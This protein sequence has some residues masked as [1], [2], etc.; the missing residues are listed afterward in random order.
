FFPRAITELLV[1]LLLRCAEQFTAAAGN[2]V[3]VIVSAGERIDHCHLCIA[4]SGY[5]PALAERRCTHAYRA[6]D[7]RV[8]HAIA[9]CIAGVRA[10]AARARA[11]AAPRQW[12]SQRAAAV[13]DDGR[14]FIRTVVGGIFT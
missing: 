12:H 7:S 10:G 2:P 14:D 4:R 5:A 13:D 8:Q 9:V 1:Y 3:G 6:F 11:Q